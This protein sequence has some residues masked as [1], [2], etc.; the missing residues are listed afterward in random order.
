MHAFRETRG[1]HFTEMDCFQNVTKG[2]FFL[3][4]WTN[5]AI[6]FIRVKKLFYLNSDS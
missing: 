6:G 3:H 4:D 2:K 5:V 1:K